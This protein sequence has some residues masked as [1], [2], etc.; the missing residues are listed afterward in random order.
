MTIKCFT[1]RLEEFVV[2]DDDDDDDVG[3]GVGAG[4]MVGS[5]VP[6]HRNSGGAWSE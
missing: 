4:A 5:S 2:F 3:E 1:N 6:P